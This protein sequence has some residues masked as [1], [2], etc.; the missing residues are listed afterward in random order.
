MPP[1]EKLEQELREAGYGLGV[2]AGIGPAIDRERAV[3]AVCL[4][5][6][7]QGLEYLPFIRPGSYVRVY[8]CK[9]GSA[10]RGR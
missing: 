3:E 4:C 9:C 10:A 2:P 7:E 6:G 1:R 8:A 5:C